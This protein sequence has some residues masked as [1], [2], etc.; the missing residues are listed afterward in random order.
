MRISAL[1][2][3]FIC[4]LPAVLTAK[5]ITVR[6]GEHADFSRLV[7]Y[8]DQ[9]DTPIF[10]RTE[11]GFRLT[12]GNNT[13]WFRTT[14]VFDLIPRQRITDL[15]SP[16]GGIL[17][18][19]VQC[20][21]SALTET[22]P[23][24]QFVIDITDTPP[25]SNDVNSQSEVQ[26]ADADKAPKPLLS[27]QS[28][29]RG[30]P[31]A[32]DVASGGLTETRNQPEEN[33][34]NVK[35]TS[36]ASAAESHPLTEEKLLRQLARAASQGLVVAPTTPAPPDVDPQPNP[37]LAERPQQS[38]PLALP[39]FPNEHIRVQTSVDRD[40][41]RSNGRQAATDT[42][43]A[44]FP[45]ESFAI[46]DWGVGA[47]S[48]L[49]FAAHR[50]DL[51]TEFDKTDPGT[52]EQFLRHQIYLTL[53]AEAQTYMNVYDG[54][55]VDDANLRLMADIVETGASAD[56]ARMTAQLTCDGPVVL[57]AVLSHP[58][59]PRNQNINRAA[60][61]S[62]F[63]VLPRHLRVHLGPML[64]RKFLAIG[65]TET[66]IEIN[67]IIQRG[68]QPTDTA[69]ALSEAQLSLA[70]GNKTQAR[71]TLAKIVDT[72]DHNSVE[73]MLLLVE[74][75]IKN[76]Q[77]IPNRTLELLA[78]LAL[79]HKN[80]EKGADLAIAE[81]RVLIHVSR[82]NEARAK[83]GD[84]KNFPDRHNDGHVAILNE[85]GLA[86]TKSASDGTFLRFTIGQPFWPEASEATRVSMAN[87]LLNLGFPTG[88]KE[89]LL[90]QPSA[91]GREARLLIAKAA[92]ADGDAKVALG[93]LAGLT[94]P[95]AQ[96]L[97]TAALSATGQFA[98]PA[99][100]SDEMPPSD[101][102]DQNAETSL[103]AFRA[104]IDG[105]RENRERIENALKKTPTL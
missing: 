48:P 94:S 26:K 75:Q 20:N 25:P 28:A 19:G 41:G 81:G 64:M 86:L 1:L 42:G 85:F 105:S 31:I 103:T 29:R 63:S 51:V 46:A 27:A 83:L 22:L 38:E 92:L 101:D 91:P 44:C 98:A 57:W 97:R 60:V 3:C 40:L 65:D 18:I 74:N 67:G 61:I 53:G 68:A 58:R 50:A 56:F 23:G 35:S 93:Y 52:F 72:D 71:E 82:F 4:C 43:L 2:S 47:D 16:A 7:V 55:L 49:D 73:A 59:L 14:G 88:A 36:Q 62:E 70:T 54:T 76:R 90:K 17:D 21:C 99:P 30:L 87:R 11:T 33:Y 77:G 104:L 39:R 9:A 79:E 96:R 37:Q 80:T 78:S 95:E 102:N 24:G 8:V 100:Q 10:T 15:T 12:T 69:H 13:D 45:V 32:A 89:I 34:E 84:M 66:A 5:E 6:S